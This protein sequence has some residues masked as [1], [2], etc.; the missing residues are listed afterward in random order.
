MASGPLWSAS[1]DAA[2]R[3]H[4]PCSDDATITAALPG[5]AWAS[6]G[7]RACRLKVKR[8]RNSAAPPGVD[9]VFVLLRK[10]RLRRG[11]SQSALA[12][13]LGVNR[14]TLNRWEVGRDTPCWAMVTAW[15]RV[16]GYR[17]DATL[18]ISR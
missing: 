10:A 13:Q 3:L 8:T 5:R 1:E 18:I 4:W 15:A 9:R 12:A 17:L 11:L 7:V 2:V 6:I 14:V 16:L